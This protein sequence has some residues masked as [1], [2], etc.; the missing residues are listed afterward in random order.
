MLSLDTS[1]RHR[2]N[3]EDPADDA[4][5]GEADVAAVAA[6]VEYAAELAADD[7]AWSAV[8]YAV[9]LAADDVA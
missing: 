6:V 7:V 5:A 3:W 2:R 4:V 9:E 8:E 1:Q